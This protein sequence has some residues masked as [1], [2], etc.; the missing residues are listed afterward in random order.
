MNRFLFLAMDCKYYCVGGPGDLR[1]FLPSREDDRLDAV[2]CCVQRAVN[3]NF[4]LEFA[5]CFLCNFFSLL[6]YGM[7]IS[8]IIERGNFEQ[9]ADV[10]VRYLRGD[11]NIGLTNIHFRLLNHNSKNS[12]KIDAYKL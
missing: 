7:Q 5:N 8:R 11:M 4:F 9:D 1:F 10:C 6:F 3:K 2:F 12:S